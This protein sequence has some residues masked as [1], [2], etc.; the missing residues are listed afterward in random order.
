[1]FANTFNC[2]AAFAQHNNELTIAPGILTGSLVNS[3]TEH[4]DLFVIPIVRINYGTNYFEARYNYDGEDIFG[5]YFGRKLNAG[6]REHHSFV[7]QV[8]ALIGRGT[9]V[10]V[11]LYYSLVTKVLILNFENQYSR[12]LSNQRSSFYYNWSSI[13][14]K[15]ATR[16]YAGLSSQL[17]LANNYHYND[18]GVSVSYI[19]KRYSLVVFDF[20]PYEKAR[21]YIAI[22]IIGSI[23]S[24][25]NFRKRANPSARQPEPYD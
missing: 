9:G 15:L 17:Y 14:T 3:P 10:S 23:N 18:N 20:N 8:G 1:M 22:G 6:R 4:L 11:Q 21:H 7:P 25:D 13:Y 19:R 16:I 12:N 2:S 24:K 5:L